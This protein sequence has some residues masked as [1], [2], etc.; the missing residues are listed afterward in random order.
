M[1][2]CGVSRI[3]FEFYY[4]P[5]LKKWGYTGFALSFHQFVVLSFCHSFQMKLEYLWGQLASLEQILY[6]VS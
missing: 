5:A 1:I 3:D 4:G 6:E 2:M